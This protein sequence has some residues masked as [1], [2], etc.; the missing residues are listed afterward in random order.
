MS[1]ALTQFQPA[2]NLASASHNFRDSVIFSRLFTAESKICSRGYKYVRVF[3]VKRKFLDDVCLCSL[4]SWSHSNHLSLHFFFNT[5]CSYKLM[6]L[7]LIFI[8]WS[9][10]PWPHRRLFSFCVAS[11]LYLSLSIAFVSAK[12]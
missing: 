6:Y 7:R 1:T 2:G 11:C 3:P 10:T 12:I 4:K 8:I 5:Q 9:R